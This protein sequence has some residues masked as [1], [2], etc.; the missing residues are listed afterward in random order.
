MGEFIIKQGWDPER[1]VAQVLL[2]ARYVPVV[3]AASSSD[4]QEVSAFTRSTVPAKL[5]GPPFVF[6]S[7]VETAAAPP[8]IPDEQAAPSLGSFVV[9]IQPQ[10]GFRRLH[11]VGDCSYRPGVHYGVFESLGD[12]PLAATEFQA[13]CKLCFKEG[14][15]I[16]VSEEETATSVGSSSPESSIV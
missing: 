15:P 6:S 11:R 1:A 12:A 14:P 3:R 5:D 9:S 10:S 2:L 16:Q 8:E 7:E 4:Q 13:R